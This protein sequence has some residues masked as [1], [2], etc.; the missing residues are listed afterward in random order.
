MLY[1]SDKKVALR[2]DTTRETPWKWA[3][4]RPEFPRPVKL[5]NGCT[6]WRLPDLEAFEATLTARTEEA[7]PSEEGN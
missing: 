5:S 7:S 1:L 6:R 2:Y 4:T 3:R